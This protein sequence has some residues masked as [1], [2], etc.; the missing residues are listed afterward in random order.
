M[1]KNHK[2]HYESPTPM[3]V[4]KTPHKDELFGIL[5]GLD[6]QKVTNYVIKQ[7]IKHKVPMLTF[8]KQGQIYKVALPYEWWEKYFLVA[9]KKKDTA[10]DTYDLRSEFRLHQ[11]VYESVDHPQVQVPELFGYQ[12]LPNGEQY[13]VMEFAPGQTIYTLLLNKVTEKNKPER[14][15]A[16]ND[17]EA[18]TNIVKIFGVEKAKLM[19]SKIETTPYIYSQ[20]KW[21]NLFTQKQAEDI[22]KNITEFLSEMHAKWIYHRDLWGSIRNMLLCPDGKI[23]VIDFGKA[24]KKHHIKNEKE[25]YT[26]NTEHGI[27][28][29]FSD[30]EILDIIDAYTEKS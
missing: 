20:M 16:Q 2:E 8:W 23:Y 12:E 25:I 14:P 27:N 28:E 15:V 11:A 21:M 10:D 4:P 5:E 19:L 24:V 29:Y 6:K 26:E 1:T 3:A 30:E 13:I 18:D 7:V 17:R 22:K 9:K